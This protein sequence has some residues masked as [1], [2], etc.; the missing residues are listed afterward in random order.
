MELG[1]ADRRTM[2]APAGAEALPW[3][4]IDRHCPRNIYQA[5]VFLKTWLQYRRGRALPWHLVF[6]GNDGGLEFVAPLVLLRERHLWATL[7]VLKPVGWDFLWPGVCVPFARQ[8]LARLRDELLVRRGEWD[9]L[10]FATV[11]ADGAPAPAAT[12]VFAQGGLAV[13][14]SYQPGYPYIAIT[15]S[16]EAYY[17]ARSRNLRKNIS[18]LLGKAG[19]LG[20]RYAYADGADA[21]PALE[22]LFALHVKRW[23]AR[24]QRSVYAEEANRAFMDALCR[25]C[26]PARSASVHSLVKDGKAIAAAVCLASADVLHFH[27]TAFDVDHAALSPGKLLL[28]FIIRDAFQRGLREVNLGL[29]K[30]AY[31]Y[32]WATG[33]RTLSRFVVLSDREPAVWLERILRSS[34]RAMKRS[35]AGARARLTQDPHW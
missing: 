6:R 30:D 29:S 11:T 18:W 10:E 2:N 7:R 14:A 26:S 25:A 28:Y 15:D 20:I 12:D 1:R 34:W 33:G 17:R 27:H 16:W 4:W 35:A 19:R 32:W 24:G 22:G 5:S 8:H 3:D 21:C 23:A 31:K 13:H 9:A